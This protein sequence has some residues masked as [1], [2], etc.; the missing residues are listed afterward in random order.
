MKNRSFIF[1]LSIC[2]CTL[3]GL[4]SSA[5]AG[6]KEGE[7]LPDLHSY[8]L[9]GNIPDLHGKVV[10]LDFWASWCAPCKA[11]FPVLERWQK[12]FSGKGF[13]VLGVSV[14][15]TTPNMQTFL[16]NNP[17]TFPVVHD[18]SHKL[19]AVADVATMPTSFIIDRHGVIHQVHHGFR[20]SDEV[21]LTSLISELL[22]QK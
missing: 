8:G 18:S 11:S 6:W 12:Q 22:N 10:Y 13:T 20:A 1:L 7:P 21:A 19:V 16:K 15:E 2:F 3:A 4:I 14:D 5:S 17:V 9:A